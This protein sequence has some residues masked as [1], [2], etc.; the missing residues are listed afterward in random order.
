MVSLVIFSTLIAASISA[1]VLHTFSFLLRLFLLA[2]PISVMLD[3]VIQVTDYCL[4][5]SGLGMVAGNDTGN[6]FFFMKCIFVIQEELVALA[7]GDDFPFAFRRLNVDL[8]IFMP[9]G[10]TVL[11]AKLIDGFLFLFQPCSDNRAAVAHPISSD[12]CLF[13]IEELLLIFFAD[14]AVNIAVRKMKHFLIAFY[15]VKYHESST[16]FFV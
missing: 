7:A 11:L 10:N 16:P 9:A 14:T 4:A 5:T 3:D 2:L 15:A 1:K 8:A 6:A 13:F 12:P